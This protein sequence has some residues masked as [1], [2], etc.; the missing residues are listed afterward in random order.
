MNNDREALLQQIYP[1]LELVL[2]FGVEIGEKRGQRNAPEEW[3]FITEAA[4]AIFARFEAAG[5]PLPAQPEGLEPKMTPDEQRR[6]IALEPTLRRLIATAHGLSP[7]GSEIAY[8]VM[9]A[10]RTALWIA[11]QSGARAVSIDYQ[12]REASMIA[13]LTIA[14]DAFRGY[15]LQ[16]RAKEPPQFD[17]AGRNAVLASICDMAIKGEV[18]P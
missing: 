8:H 5:L 17:K 18:I 10:A 3:K 7:D 6:A 2:R 15:A 13:A 11:D 4:E 9:V 12:L 1:L 14:R 16:H